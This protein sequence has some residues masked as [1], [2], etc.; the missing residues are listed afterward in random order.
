M[1]VALVDLG[2]KLVQGNCRFRDGSHD[3]LT[4]YDPDLHD[5]VVRQENLL[6]ERFRDPQGE[7]VPPFPD[8]D[9]YGLLSSRYLQ[10]RNV[11]I[12]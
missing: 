12:G 5:G 4:V 9:Y 8:P 1:Q 2:Q 11:C 3:E 6:R 10:R 7:T